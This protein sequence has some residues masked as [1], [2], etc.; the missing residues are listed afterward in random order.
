MENHQSW[1]DVDLPMKHGDLT[2][3]FVALYQ[4]VHKWLNYV[5][6]SWNHEDCDWNGGFLSWTW[7]LWKNHGWFN[8]RFMVVQPE[9]PGVLRR[10]TMQNKFKQQK[11][12]GFLSAISLKKSGRFDLGDQIIPSLKSQRTTWAEMVECILII[13]EIKK[14]ILDDLDNDSSLALPNHCHDVMYIKYTASGTW[15]IPSQGIPAEHR[16]RMA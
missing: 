1:N 16:P 12:A 3:S 15:E 11:L 13:L 8:L 9:E 14:W 10:F 5:K 6:S 2:H 4:R 7:R